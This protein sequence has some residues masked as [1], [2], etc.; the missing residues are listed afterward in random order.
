MMGLGRRSQT[1][2]TTMIFDL[3]GCPRATCWQIENIKESCAF[4]V[5]DNLER[6]GKAKKC[7]MALSAELPILER[8][9]THNFLHHHHQH[10]WGLRRRRFC[11]VLYFVRVKATLDVK[12]W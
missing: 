8:T 2:G 11:S 5:V 4:L 1:G 7:M 9:F 6:Y 3:S 10:G 12:G